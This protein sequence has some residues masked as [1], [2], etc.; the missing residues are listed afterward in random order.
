MHEIGV[1]AAHAMLS[2]T[3]AVSAMT[4][5]VGGPTSALV[6][7]VLERVAML[8]SKNGWAMTRQ[9]LY[10]T[11]T[12]GRHWEATGPSLPKSA[13]VYWQIASSTALWLAV[14]S[15]HANLLYHTQNGGKRWESLRLPS[16]KGALLTGIA[17]AKGQPGYATYALSLSPSGENLAI[18]CSSNQG[19][20]WHLA[21]EPRLPTAGI[22]SGLALGPGSTA[23]LAGGSA[24]IGKIYLYR[25]SKPQTPWRP[26]AVAVPSL[27]KQ[28]LFWSTPP[29][30]F[31]PQDGVLPVFING[32][33]GDPLF[34]VTR[35][36]G[37]T[38]SPGSPVV[39][40]VAAGGWT[41]AEWKF[42]NP[43]LGFAWLKPS[44]TNPQPASALY[45]T[46]DGGIHWT[47]VAT[48]PKLAKLRTLDLISA[49]S[50]FAIPKQGRGLVPVGILG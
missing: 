29:H 40:L 32:T 42:I 46:T 3:L 41:L 8:N 20:K 16:P 14:V 38:F 18:Y 2:L 21:P 39:P 33:E 44:P 7:P 25:Q 12:G 15:P 19:R 17:F 49:K 10:R 31:S 4:I 27:L 37:K 5:T 11:Q 30:F 24:T 13:T 9:R 28:A 50:G 1:R 22:K 48:R 43:R 23:W 34:Y 45:R 6:Q 47:K 35:N 26:V 36:G